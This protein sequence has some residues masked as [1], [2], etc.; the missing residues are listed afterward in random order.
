MNQG[1]YV[2]VAVVDDDCAVLEAMMDLLASAGLTA[3]RFSSAREFLD[4]GALDSIGCLV[5]D[6]RMPGM[7]GWELRFIVAARRPELPIILITAHEGGR[8]VAS[9]DGHQILFS[10]PFDA[11][12]LL[13]AITSVLRKP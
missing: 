3:C 7:D 12:R 5:S 9:P 4:S 8:Q 13:A 2:D 1:S 6:I 10:K 11:Q